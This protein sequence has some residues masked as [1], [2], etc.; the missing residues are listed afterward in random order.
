MTTY[1]SVA[2]KRRRT[3][4]AA[5]RLAATTCYRPYRLTDDPNGKRTLAPLARRNTRTG[6]LRAE[7]WPFPATH[8]PRMP[9]TRWTRSPDGTTAKAATA[10][11]ALRRARGPRSVTKGATK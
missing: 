6:A 4:R 2:Y 8:G 9:K 7:T 10:I 5:A 11:G 1:Y 3:L